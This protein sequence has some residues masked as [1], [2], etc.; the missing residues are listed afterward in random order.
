VDHV[1]GKPEYDTAAVE[2]AWQSILEQIERLRGLQ[3]YFATI[4]QTT[5]TIR[6][7]GAPQWAKQLASEPAI[8]GSFDWTPADWSAAW[9]WSRQFGYLLGID[10]RSRMQSLATQRHNLGC[11]LSTAYA[12]LVQ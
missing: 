1:L 9:K 8:E 11:D 3:P 4:R 5:D 7:A 2:T 12:Q 10:G 6:A